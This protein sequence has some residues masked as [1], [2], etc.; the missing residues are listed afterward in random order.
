MIKTAGDLVATVLLQ[1][2]KVNKVIILWHGSKLWDDDDTS[3][4]IDFQL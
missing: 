4:E 2:N 1:G 3:D